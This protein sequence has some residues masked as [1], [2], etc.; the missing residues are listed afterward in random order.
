MTP[1]PIYFNNP[2]LRGR[3]TLE[4]AVCGG[5]CADVAIAGERDR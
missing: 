4:E 5:D 1:P 2:A 3:L